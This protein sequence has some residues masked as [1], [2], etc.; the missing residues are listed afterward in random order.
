MTLQALNLVLEGAQQFSC[1]MANFS[2]GKFKI[3]LEL[4]KGTT[5]KAQGTAAIS[6]DAVGYS[7]A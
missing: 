2:G 7:K 1:G 5:A 4:A 3:V 6:V